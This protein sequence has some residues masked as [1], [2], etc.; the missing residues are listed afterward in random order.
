MW[1]TTAAAELKQKPHLQKKRE[2][3]TGVGHKRKQS[4]KN[5]NKNFF[6]FGKRISFCGWD[7]GRM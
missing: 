7:F 1:K 4:R 5:R 2:P 3:S 6:S